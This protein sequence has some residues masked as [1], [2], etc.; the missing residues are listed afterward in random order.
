VLEEA[1]ERLRPGGKLV[2]TYAVMARAAAAAER[3]GD[4][5]QVSIS[6]GAWL[7]DSS[8]RLAA[9]DPVFVCWGPK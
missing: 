6:R 8:I 3:L 4:I 9:Q 7:P 2:A 1:L 5:V